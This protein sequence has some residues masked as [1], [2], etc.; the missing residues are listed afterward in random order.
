MRVKGVALAGEAAA[1]TVARAG[2][3]HTNRQPF[4]MIWERHARASR[5]FLIACLRGRCEFILASRGRLWRPAIHSAS[6]AAKEGAGVAS[7]PCWR[8][9]QRIAEQVSRQAEH[10]YNYIAFAH[11]CNLPKIEAPA[12]FPLAGHANGMP[13][14]GRASRRIRS[15]SARGAPGDRR[16][17]PGRQTIG[18]PPL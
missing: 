15:K 6:G 3:S 7:W 1:P 17:P 2:A 14:A 12:T 10:T 11:E 13:C 9:A 8:S 16:R 18:P 5:L 4:P